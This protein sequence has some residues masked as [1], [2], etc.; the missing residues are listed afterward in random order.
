EYLEAERTHGDPR[1]QKLLSEHSQTTLR[2]WLQELTWAPSEALWD[3]PDKIRADGI[4][5]PE[6]LLTRQLQTALDGV[7][8]EL[9]LVS[10]YF[11]PTRDGVEYFAGLSESGVDIKVLTNALEATDV[12]AVHGGYA[13]YRR[14][15]LELGVR[16]YEMRRQPD[17]DAP[18]SFTGDSESS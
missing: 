10:A 2:Q 5:D 6:L 14:E 13:P 3:H 9:V 17:Q 8:R 12:P 1:L 15:L 4:P 7:Q 11:V 16:L 18:V